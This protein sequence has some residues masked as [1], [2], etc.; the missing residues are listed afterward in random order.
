[1]VGCSRTKGA[2]SMLDLRKVSIV[3]PSECQFRQ[4]DINEDSMSRKQQ[5]RKQRPS[6]LKRRIPRIL[7]DVSEDQISS[8][9]IQQ[10]PQEK[11]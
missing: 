11:R 9:I 4:S 7:G 2:G 3:E 5:G 8:K 6:F 10:I 1:M